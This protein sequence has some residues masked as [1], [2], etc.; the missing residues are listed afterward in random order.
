MKNIF[1]ALLILIL[2][3]INASATTWATATSKHESNG[4]VIIFR[5]IKEFD[6]DFKRSDQPTRI[7]LVWRYEGEKGMPNKAEHA[8]M[9]ELEDAL[10]PM[11]ESG[12]FSTLAL[13][14]TGEGLREWIYYTKSEEAFFEKLNLALRELKPFPIEIHSADDPEWKNYEE[15]AKTVKE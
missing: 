12:G 4:R 3:P 7:I 8:R 2:M 6:K 10:E 9:N 11:V 1:L 14:S 15:F 5:Y 13:V